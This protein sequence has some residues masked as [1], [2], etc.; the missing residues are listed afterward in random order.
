MTTLYLCGATNLEGVRLALNINRAQSR[1][2][3]I[4]VLDDDPSKHGQSI[5][6]VEIAGP[7][8]LLAQADPASSEV[9]NLVTRTTKGRQS[10]LRKIHAYGLPFAP[11]IDPSVDITWVEFGKDITVYRNAT[12]C[13]N[14]KVGE[15]SAILGG[16][17]VGHGSRVGKC[18]VAAPGAVINARVEIADGVYIG[19]N[20]SILPDLRIGPWATIGVNSAVVQDVPAGATVMGVPAQLLKPGG[21]KF[22][23]ESSAGLAG[24]AEDQQPCHCSSRMQQNRRE[25]RS[26]GLRR[27][28]IAQEKYIGSYRE[29][30][31]C[32]LIRPGKDSKPE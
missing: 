30:R 17:M 9:S 28:R 25:V 2:D 27:L 31:G 6:G 23:N 10:A 24:R 18:C 13:A 4:I 1:W 29:Q 8:T 26:D 19:T 5:L 15:G 21:D 32:D 3:R 16:A 7:F 12:L 11:L 14:A 20:A 22:S